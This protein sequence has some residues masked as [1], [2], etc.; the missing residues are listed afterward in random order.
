MAKFG[1]ITNLK[2]SPI[3]IMVLDSPP[4][5]QQSIPPPVV[6]QPIPPSVIAK[7]SVS[8]LPVVK[9]LIPS[10]DQHPSSIVKPPITMAPLLILKMLKANWPTYSCQ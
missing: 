9:S 10:R 2:T 3:K 4:I 8:P 5:V 7:A 1:D 6:Q